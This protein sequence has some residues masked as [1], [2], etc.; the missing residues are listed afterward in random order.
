MKIVSLEHPSKLLF[1]EALDYKNPYDFTQIHKHDYFE[2]IFVE[3]GGGSQL[4]DDQRFTLEDLS[5]FIIQ[6]GQVHLLNREVAEGKII[7]FGKDIF[8]HM[9][10][11]EFHHLLFKQPRVQISEADFFHLYSLIE[12]MGTVIKQE[13]ASGLAIFKSYSYLQIILIHLI[14]KHSVTQTKNSKLAA[15]FL[16]LLSLHIKDKRNVVD[17]A[18]MLYVSV[19]TLNCHCKLNFGK[20]PLSLINEE[21]VKETKRLMLLGTHSIVEIAYELNFNSPSN[22]SSFIKKNTG[23]TP[24]QLNVDIKNII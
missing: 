10:P 8:A 24:K 6:P 3:K 4:I 13:E 23:K 22:F 18:N 1:V 5:V 19:D 2:I 20:T 9:F 12:H 17:Y 7:Q 15:R 21:V 14:E 11:L 16:E